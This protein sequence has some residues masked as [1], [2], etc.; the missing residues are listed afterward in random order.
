MC[1]VRG[2]GRREKEREVQQGT[3]GQTTCWV[4]AT[5][6]QA[7]QARRGTADRRGLASLELVSWC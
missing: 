1:E 4:T 3:K 2:V 5:A 7:S 6:S